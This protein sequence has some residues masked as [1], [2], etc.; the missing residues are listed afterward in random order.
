MASTAISV[1]SP[2][3]NWIWGCIAPHVATMMPF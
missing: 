2:F 1:M 3:K